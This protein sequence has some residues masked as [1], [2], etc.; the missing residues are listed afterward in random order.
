MKRIL[1][2]LAVLAVSACANLEVAGPV[3]TERALEF[4]VS[5]SQHGRWMETPVI[6]VEGRTGSIA[7]NAWL[8]TPDP[9]RTLSAQLKGSGSDVIIEVTIRP[10]D[11]G[12]CYQVIGTFEYNAVVRGLAPGSYRLRVVHTY[13]E[14]G[15]PTATVDRQVEVR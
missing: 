6:E 5:G 4:S 9:C 14:T 2:A 11:N 8:S 10:R 13:L 15:W 3:D 7:L 12:G 1:V